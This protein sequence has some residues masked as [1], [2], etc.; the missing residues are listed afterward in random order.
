MG[1]MSSC[2]II[3]GLLPARP[4]WLGC[5]DTRPALWDV[6][7]LRKGLSGLA[8]EFALDRVKPG[9]GRSEFMVSMLSTELALRSR[10][11]YLLLAAMLAASPSNPSRSLSL[12]FA[13]NLVP[14]CLAT[15]KSAYDTE[16]TAR[17]RS[18]F[19]RSCS[20]LNSSTVLCPL[21]AEPALAR[22][23]NS[24]RAT[25]SP[26]S[27][28]SLLNRL[29]SS[30]SSFSRRRARRTWYKASISAS[31]CCSSTSAPSG[32]SITTSIPPRS[33]SLPSTC[34]VSRALG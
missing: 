14:S 32:N 8:V 7:T 18:F 30:R 10:R 22:A 27:L 11:W 16:D 25:K 24:L 3:S 26:L 31:R 34:S 4:S 20:A 15:P 23:C 13:R 33:P 17:C 5:G 6:E 28:A 12:L 29:R 19:I 2:S 21:A 1:G 9:E